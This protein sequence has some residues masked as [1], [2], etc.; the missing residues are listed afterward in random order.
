MEGEERESQGEERRQK[1]GV[2]RTE[3][4]LRGEKEIKKT[5]RKTNNKGV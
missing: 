2:K 4:D 1:W 3:Q 5:E